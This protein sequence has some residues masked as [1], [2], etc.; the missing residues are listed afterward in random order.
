MSSKSKG[1]TLW[2]FDLDNTLSDGMRRFKAA[3]Q[4]PN[5]DTQRDQ[6]DVWLKKVMTNI[7]EDGPVSPMMLMFHRLYTDAFT[8]TIILTARNEQHRDETNEWLKRHF[9][10]MPHLFMRP[11]SNF[12]PSGRLKES[13]IKDLLVRFE[14]KD[15]VV[16]DDDPL[17][18]LKPLCSKNG[19]LF[20][21][22]CLPDSEQVSDSL[23]RSKERLKH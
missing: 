17:E 14:C 13:L 16:V 8:P 18:D 11:K 1:Q 5:R 2:V 12:W 21:K 3:G 23:K 6:Y 20:L 22:V 9:K 19:W 15:A 4:E 7:H 10:I